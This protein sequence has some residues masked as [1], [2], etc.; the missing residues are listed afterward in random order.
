M[1]YY[2][3]LMATQGVLRL[4]YYGRVDVKERLQALD[5]VLRMCRD[6]HID[7]L[8][9]DFTEQESP[10]IALDA[11]ALSS[12]LSEAGLPQCLRIAYLCTTGGLPVEVSRWFS[13]KQNLQTETFTSH[14]GAYRW[15]AEA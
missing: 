15:L 4:R 1:P 8:L 10:S 3:S 5:H 6:Q 12:T 9:V 14:D 2:L 13:K 7:K 11:W